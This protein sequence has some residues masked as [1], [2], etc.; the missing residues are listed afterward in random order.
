MWWTLVL[1]IGG[2]EFHSP[3]RFRSPTEALLY[4]DRMR[5]MLVRSGVTIRVSIIQHNGRGNRNTVLLMNGES[6]Q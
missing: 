1:T 3:L 4:S 2:E 5:F 6:T